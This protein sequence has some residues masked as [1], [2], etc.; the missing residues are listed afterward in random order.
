MIEQVKKALSPAE[1]EALAELPES[2][3]D[4]KAMAITSQAGPTCEAR[5]H[6]RVVDPNASS[7]ELDLLRA[8][9]VTSMKSVAESDGATPDQATCVEKGFEELPENELIAIGNGSKTVR[10]GI[11][12]SL[13]ALHRDEVAAGRARSPGAVA[14]LVRARDS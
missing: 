11:L 6:L 12:R 7:K 5:H 4:E 14:Q 1:A 10:E 9:Y 2:E 13:Q 8:G 3:R